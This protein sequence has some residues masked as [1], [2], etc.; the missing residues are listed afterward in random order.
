MAR[1][2]AAADLGLQRRDK[3]LQDHR[4]LAGAGYASD[5]GQPPLGDGD[6]QR[7]DGVDLRRLQAERAVRKERL[8]CGTATQLR[9]CPP[10]EKWADLRGRVCRDGRDRPL[11]D[12]MAA[13]CPGLRPQFD[14]PVCFL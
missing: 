8:L 11:G 14:D 10:G 3:T 2:C 13:V 1:Q 9:L 5:N 7:L 12:D 6:V 4:C